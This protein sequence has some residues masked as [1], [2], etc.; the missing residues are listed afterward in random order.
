MI[1]QFK[2]LNYNSDFV[3]HL[4]LK[5]HNT[6]RVK[7]YLRNIFIFSFLFGILKFN[8]LCNQ[9]T[10]FVLVV[11]QSHSVHAIGAYK[12]LLQSANPTPNLDLIASQ[13]LL[14]HKAFCVNASTGPSSACLLTGSYSHINR[15]LNNKDAFDYSVDSLPRTFQN[16]GYETAM[17]GR[18]DLSTKPKYFNFWDILL[19][20]SEKYNPEFLS[21]DKKRKIEGHS[22]DIITDIAIQW[23]AR[24][25]KTKPYFLIIQY[26]AT[27]QPWMPA[28]RH[29]NLFDD[30][31][32]PEPNT[33]RSKHTGKASPSRYQKMSLSKDLDFKNDLFFFDKQKDSNNTFEDV[34]SLGEK[35]FEAM[36]PEQ[37][38]AWSVSWRPKNEAFLREVV[39]DDD[40]LSW[41]YQRF[42]KNYLRC[43]R[44]IDENIKRINNA[45]PSKDSNKTFFIYTANQGRFLGNNGW[46]GSKWFYETSSQIPLIISYDSSNNFSKIEHS[47]VK[48]IDI[49]TTILD[50]AGLKQLKQNQG[51]SL[52]KF[53]D[54]GDNNHTS[55]NQYI[56][57][58]HHEFPSK[59]MVAK[60]YGIR[61]EKFKLI[62][63]YQF[64]EWEFY[65]LMNDPFE[66]KNLYESQI[67]SEEILNLKKTLIN[68]RKKYND[69]TDISIM[70]DVWRK[71]YRGPEA[72]KK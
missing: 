23:M 28:I 16:A 39:S 37:L 48:N 53:I 63:F 38:S 26:N 57:Y 4:Y 64:N 17:I 21:G 9:K 8:G 31:L 42:I 60:H 33:L 15:F 32:M 34:E 69:N 56:Y 59:Q 55:K 36:T 35:N 46:F 7:F 52:R 62:H 71:S 27:S 22:T 45:I 40:L 65:D 25:N 68:A 72:R 54:Y 11:T 3:S 18:W 44:G 47:L 19:D 30:K 1:L 14:F 24:R 20:S 66:T 2:S 29:L 51:T 49:T 6:H 43:I 13:S 10:N 61:T 70:P 5:I 12:G 41:K 58:H 50:Y 67:H